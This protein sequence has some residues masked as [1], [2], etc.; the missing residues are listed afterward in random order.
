MEI[1][2]LLLDG[3]KMTDYDLTKCGDIS[4]YLG[5]NCNFDCDY[6]DRGPIK[7]A[8][9]YTQ[10]TPKD[11]P[12]IMRFLQDVSND[13]KFPVDMLSFFGGEPFVFIKVMDRVIAESLELMKCLMGMYLLLKDCYRYYKTETIIQMTSCSIVYNEFVYD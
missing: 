2:G 13:G 1:S 5:G 3:A 7:E 11:V 4:I 6:C 8:A 12:A 9:G 10:M